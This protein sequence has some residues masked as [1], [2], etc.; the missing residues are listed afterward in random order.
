MYYQASQLEIQEIN[1]RVW[2]S[3]ATPKLVLPMRPALSLRVHVVLIHGVLV[4]EGA[5]DLADVVVQLL[6]SI[7]VDSA[8]NGPDETEEE[9]ELYHTLVVVLVSWVDLKCQSSKGIG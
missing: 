2:I 6:A 3:P 1:S 7:L 8:A 4:G 5:F 9:P